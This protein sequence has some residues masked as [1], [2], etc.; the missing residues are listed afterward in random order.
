MAIKGSLAEASL[1]E[2]IQLLSYSL[3]SG[4]L[5]ITDGTNLGNIF[6][7]DGKI[8]H[9]T[10][11][12][13]KFRLGD[14]MIEKK[15]LQGELLKQALKKQ[16]AKKG[17][18]LGEILIE[19]DAISRRDL[20]QE[21]T[22]QV[23]EAVQTMLGWDKG[24][25]NFE[26]GL[27]P[28]PSEHTV[29]I[30]AQDLLLGGARLTDDWHKIK[31]R[32]PSP[33]T[34]L[35]S[36]QNVKDFDLTEP[37]R[38]I[39]STVDGVKTVDDI[40]KG[41]GLDYRTACKA[42]Y[43]LLVA[44]L[45][46]RPKRATE[47]PPERIDVDEHKGAGLA[48]YQRGQFDEAGI[49]F[50]KILERDP[51]NGEALFYLGLVEIARHNDE[52]AMRYLKGALEKGQRV[53]TLI[54]IGYVSGRTGSLEEAIRYLDE[55]RALEPDS[56][57]VLLGLGIMYFRRGEEEDAARVLERCLELSDA[58]LTPY[59][60]LSALHVRN[61]ETDK[62]VSL[63]SAAVEK[64]PGSSPLKNNLA[65]LEENAGHYQEAE[66]LYRQALMDEPDN[67]TVIGNLA[68]LYYRLSIFGLA[69]E[70][71]EKIP[72]SER[73]LRVLLNIGRLCLY[74]GDKENAVA[75]WRKAIALN[76]G[77]EKLGRDIDILS[78]SI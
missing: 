71:Y 13:R 57:K 31:D 48:F 65:L 29:V 22:R 74:K 54:D 4:C 63:L 28:S 1:P 49:E 15:V 53:S 5:S 18:R 21:L 36:R 12:K 69:R 8:I 42:L 38:I 30:A 52:D 76:P 27:L 11:M 37:E 78:G 61:G 67:V 39:L 56:V 62:A 6:I 17:M 40:V 68:D 3:K 45:I 64:F 60:Y 32:I 43:V 66:A 46:E 19:M 14:S 51:E 34:V 16:R 70:W 20:E 47:A 58:V 23:E 77:D 55:A 10:L 2:V 41:S 24:Y 7:K 35:S 9:A 73:D 26:T 72:E 33:E 50:G 44:G 25:F 59:F 75:E